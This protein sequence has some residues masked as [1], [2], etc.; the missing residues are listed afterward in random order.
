MTAVTS[1]VLL[2]PLIS[3]INAPQAVEGAENI[4]NFAVQRPSVPPKGP[5]ISP[6]EMSDLTSNTS[7][8][9]Y[10]VK[11]VIH[12]VFSAIGLV[13][14]EV[15]YSDIPGHRFS[16]SISDL[17][18]VDIGKHFPTYF[19]YWNSNAEMLQNPLA[20]AFAI[21][22]VMQKNPTS[23]SPTFVAAN[24]PAQI[25]TQKSQ[26]NYTSSKSVVQ[27]EILRYRGNKNTQKN[28]KRGLGSRLKQFIKNLFR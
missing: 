5:L 15:K 26:T 20:S 7:Y 14:S 24:N 25:N 12:R 10:G 22:D 28:Q 8:E 23:A 9:D 4:S 27:E 21:S 3:P 11:K 19:S 13:N 17:D 2:A 1:K 6:T 16:I 18:S